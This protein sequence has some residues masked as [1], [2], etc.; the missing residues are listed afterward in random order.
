MSLRKIYTLQ[1]I[2]SVADKLISDYSDIKLWLF[3]G[4]MGVGKT[5]LIKKIVE[6]IGYK[7][8]TNSPTFSI[9]NE[10]K[11][12][13]SII[14]HLDLYRL[15]TIEEVNEIGIENYLFS[16]NLCLIEWPQLILPW[17]EDEKKIM[18]NIEVIDTQTRCI[19]VI[20]SNHR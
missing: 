18:V 12:D 19:E 5:T 17:I 2:N 11:N 9:V 16:N 4:D 6:K 1:E 13:D 7:Q 14:F 3:I 15:N 20:E 8:E 10:Y